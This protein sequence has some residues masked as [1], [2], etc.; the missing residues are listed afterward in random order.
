MDSKLAASLQ[1]LS[2]EVGNMTIRRLCEDSVITAANGRLPGPVIRAHEGDTIVVHVINESPYNMTIH[3]H[4]VFQTLSAWADGPSYITQ[5]PIIPGQ[6][7]TYKF[8]VAGQEG[9][10]WWHAHVSALRAT[11][12]GALIIK[13]RAGAEA[14]PFPKPYEEVPIILDT[15]KLKVAAGKTYARLRIINAAARSAAASSRSPA[16]SS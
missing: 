16:T 15:Y 7:Y 11:V 12:Y 6:S 1:F 3:W 13:P 10:L 9:T 2:R 4:G 5:C 14:Y 8:T